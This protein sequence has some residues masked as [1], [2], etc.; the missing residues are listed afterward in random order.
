MKNYEEI[1]PNA[2]DLQFELATRGVLTCIG[3][4]LCTAI[5]G[6]TFLDTY[7]PSQIPA[8]NLY[9]PQS[10]METLRILW[11]DLGFIVQNSVGESSNYFQT[12]Y[13]DMQFNFS[14]MKSLR[15]VSHS[16]PLA[17]KDQFELVEFGMHA[18]PLGYSR[19]VTLVL[20]AITQ[21]NLLRFEDLD[22]VEDIT[23]LHQIL[24]TA[25]YGNFMNALREGELFN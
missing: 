7:T 6:T 14:S 2:A 21:L 18:L 5:L 4:K 11:D 8:V 23:T 16:L 17:P 15:N 10:M 20:D 12:E 25:A 9:F 19:N 13:N 3:G 24:R 22:N 1:V